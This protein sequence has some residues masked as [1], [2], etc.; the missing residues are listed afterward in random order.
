MN[1]RTQQGQSIELRQP[2]TVTQFAHL[3]EGQIAKRHAFKE[4]AYETR[5]T[6]WTVRMYEHV[7]VFTR[8]SYPV[9]PE[10]T[11][12]SIIREIKRRGEL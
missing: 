1:L 5:T 7:T 2:S 6:I 11:H 9:T 4:Y 8:N 12:R 3:I 10:P